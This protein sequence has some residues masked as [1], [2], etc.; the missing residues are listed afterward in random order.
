MLTSLPDMYQPERLSGLYPADLQGAFRQGVAARENYKPAESDTQRVLAFII[1]LQVDFVLPSPIGRLGVPNAVADLQ[2]TL[3]WIYRNT[4]QIT[5]IAASIDTHTPYQ[6][7]LPSWWVGR[8]GN[9]PAPYTV[10][11]AAD[12]ANRVWT[13]LVDVEWSIYYVNELESVGKKQLMIWPFHCI[14]GSEGCALVPALNEAIMY[15]SAARRTAPTYLPKGTI[16]QTEYY[17]ALEPEVKYHQH[18]SGDVNMRFLRMVEAFDVVYVCGQARSHCVLETMHSLVR[19]FKPGMLSK[20]RLLDDCTS[21]IAGFEEQT[22]SEIMKLV[23]RG[24]RLV[25]SV[26][27]VDAL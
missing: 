23:T 19:H 11:S 6:I 26:D 24:I 13:P 4:G 5:H 1:D 8:D 12:V 20:V 15:H 7:F 22:E 14:E 18:P 17:S 25:Q 16:P 21:S 27:P 10:I 3:E 2:R 9:P